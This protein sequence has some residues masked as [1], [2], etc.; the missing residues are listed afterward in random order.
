[1][2][3]QLPGRAAAIFSGWRIAAG[4]SVIGAIVGDPFFA[5]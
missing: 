1:L 3:L 2:K 4:L 5:G